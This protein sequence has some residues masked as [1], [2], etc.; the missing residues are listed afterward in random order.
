MLCNSGCEKQE[1][2]NVQSLLGNLTDNVHRL[3]G[4]RFG[5]SF[6]QDECAVKSNCRSDVKGSGILD[7][8]SCLASQMACGCSFVQLWHGLLGPMIVTLSQHKLDRSEHYWRIL[9]NMN[10]HGEK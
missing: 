4:C 8:A 6:Q 10:D 1:F 5:A 9:R 2:G 7:A 3:R